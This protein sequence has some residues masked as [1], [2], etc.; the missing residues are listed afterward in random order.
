VLQ[1]VMYSEKYENEF[2]FRSDACW[3]VAVSNEVCLCC[4]TW[5]PLLLLLLLMIM[6][7]ETVGCLLGENVSTRDVNTGR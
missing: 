2:V 6:M 7:I 4:A 5:Q 3:L 1:R